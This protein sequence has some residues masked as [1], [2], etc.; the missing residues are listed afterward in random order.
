MFRVWTRNVQ[1]I[2]CDTS[3]RV[4]LFDD[5]RILVFSKSEHIDENRAACISQIW[6]LVADEGIHTDVLQANRIEHS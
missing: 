2:T 4:E 3:A 5:F 1:L 6:H